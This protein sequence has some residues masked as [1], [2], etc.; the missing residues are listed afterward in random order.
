MGELEK[1]VLSRIPE[2][3]IKGNFNCEKFIF[4]LPKIET[5]SRSLKAFTVLGPTLRSRF[6][7]RI[8]KNNA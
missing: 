6:C 5:N 2:S 4:T 1:K 8:D 3:L 7:N